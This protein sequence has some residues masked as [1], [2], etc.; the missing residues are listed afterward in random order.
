MNNLIS[1]VTL[2]CESIVRGRGKDWPAILPVT[3]QDMYMLWG[4]WEVGSVTLM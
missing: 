4:H 3:L 2:F 1:F